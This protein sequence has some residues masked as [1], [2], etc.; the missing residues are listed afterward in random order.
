MA[1]CSQRCTSSA[2]ARSATTTERFMP[3]RSALRLRLNCGRGDHS[4]AR[5]IKSASRRWCRS[6][7]ILSCQAITDAEFGQENPR[8]GRVLLDLLPEL[9]HEDA[10]IMGVV[11][12]RRTPH[13]FEQILVG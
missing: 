4:Y 8:L 11:H 10:Q 12:V 7:G 5:G 9:A 6:W 13:L 1:R 3:R 2:P